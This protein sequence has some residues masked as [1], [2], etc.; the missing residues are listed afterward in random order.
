M[1]ALG[2]SVIIA[3]RV[4]QY[5]QKTVDDLLE[6]ADGE[7]E[8]IV[9]LDGYWPNPPLKEDP[10]VVIIHQGTIHDNLG[11]REAI[12]AGVSIARGKYIMKIDEH[13]MVDQGYD[14]KLAADCQDNWVVIPRRFRLEPDSWTLLED[15]RPPIDYMQIDYPYQRPYD[16][17]CGLH[18]GEWRWRHYDRKHILIDDTMSWQGSCWF[19][20]KAYWDKLL[21]PLETSKYGTFTHESQEI[22]MKVWLSG[23][24][25][26]VNKKTWYAHYHKGKKGK[27]YGF[28]RAQYARHMADMEKGRLFA[29]DYWVND[30]WDSP[31]RIHSFQWLMDKFWPVPG[32]PDNWQEQ[33]RIDQEKDWSKLGEP[34][35]S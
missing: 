8:V 21:F 12:N 19:T 23:G 32:W 13:C 30:K 17:T 18:G 27:G 10:R 1:V 6:K 7:I 22:G 14:L 4:D 2:L 35:W 31:A 11:M 29:I 16:R 34:T 5:L 20:T 33:I 24:R 9:V 3:S 28:S 25:L 26:V 15:G